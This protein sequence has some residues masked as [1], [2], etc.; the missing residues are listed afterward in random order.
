[1]MSPKFLSSHLAL[2]GVLAAALLFLTGANAGVNTPHS[3]WYFGNPLLGP[4]ALTDLACA[5]TTCYAAG[6]AGTVLKSTDGGSTW[7]GL[8]TGLRLRLHRVRLAGGS[9]ESIV[10]GGGCAVRR[11]DD[12]G[13]TFARI[14]FTASD[15]SCPSGLSALAFPSDT[16]GYLA[17]E[18]G[19]VLS[20]ADRGRSFSRR[21][22]IP[23]GAPLD[24]LCTSETA[25]LAVTGGGSIQ[26]TTDGA[27][28]WTQVGSLPGTALRAV[29][30]AD[31]T[32]L[33]AVGDNLAVMKSEDGGSKWS[34]VSVT[35][36]PPGNLTSIRCSGADTCLIATATG[37]QVLRTNDGGKTFKSLV[38]STDP[39]FAVAFASAT[40]AVAVGGQGSAEVS[41]D[42]GVNWTAVGTRI[43]GHFQVLA[44][45]SASVAYAGGTDGV[46]ARTT[47]GGHTWTNVSAPTPAT[48]VGI[49]A[50]SADTV[51]VLA[52][53]GGLQRSDNGGRSY[54]IL[55]TGST[56]A[57]AAVA[58][59]D[60]DRI[61]LVGPRGIRRSENGGDSFEAV[62]DRVARS[63][64]VGAFDMA[65]PA[66]VAYG[67]STVIS[68]SDGGRTW[69]RVTLPRRT[70]VRDLTFVSAQLGYVV[71]TRGRVWRTASAGR[72]W[73]E[74]RSLGNPVRLIEFGDAHSGYAVGRFSVLRATGGPGAAIGEVLRTTDGGKSWHPQFLGTAQIADIRAAGPTD[75]A[76]AYD[77]SAFPSTLY[78]TS[79]GGDTGAP[80][81]ISITAK[82]RLLKKTGRVTV[83]GTLRPADGGEDVLVAMRRG[84][85]WIFQWA[86]VASN[87]TFVTRWTVSR[88]SVFVAQTLGDADHAGAGTTPLTVTV[89]PIPKRK[90]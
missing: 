49:A 34:R 19:A 52:N 51:L 57:P 59:L 45:V 90:R 15:A 13:Q 75:Y 69:K 31:A 61:L 48:I 78:A 58:A 20:T 86:T 43:P 41:G 29:H 46:L 36:T 73:T 65:G 53:D 4:H 76:L 72:T 38:P 1:M 60:G 22:T 89:K 10:V 50:P 84:S 70:V 63:A 68:S 17:L 87:G 67:R 85:G 82:P 32:T 25:C 30:G 33:Y 7:S 40:R 88:T 26:R 14:P 18:S 5:G 62:G 9:A 74:L 77:N 6:D 2:V 37:T 80:Q 3:G 8:V 71:D 55:N 27:A 66:I 56:V 21:T 12:G 16:V 23:G 39:T 83:T 81:S 44:P 11:S 28:S 54:R 42:A 35:G 64:A 79:S 47:D 24:L